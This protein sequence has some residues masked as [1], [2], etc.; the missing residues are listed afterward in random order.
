MSPL[1][2]DPDDPGRLAGGGRTAGRR[3]RQRPTWPPRQRGPRR[4]TSPPAVIALLL[5][6]IALTAAVLLLTVAGR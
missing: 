5:V 6:N 4:P 1:G 2:N 3:G